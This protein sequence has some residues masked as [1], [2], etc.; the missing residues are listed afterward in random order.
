MKSFFRKAIAAAVLAVSVATAGASAENPAANGDWK[1]SVQSFTFHKFN[2]VDALD[3]TAQLGLKYIELYP[4]HKMGPEFG[5]AVF[6][7]ELTADQRDQLKK[8]AADRGVKI[9]SSGVWTPS[10]DELPK[11]FEFARDMGME[12]VSMEPAR[13]DWDL[14][15][16]LADRYK[17]AVACHNHPNADSYW[18]PEI[19]LDNIEHR[20]HRL[21]SCADV[22]HFKRMELNAVESLRKLQGRIVSLHFKDIAPKEGAEGYDDVVWTTGV[23]DVPAMLAELKRQ[24][25]AGYFTIEYE[26]SWDNN[27]PL[28]AESIANFRAAAGAAD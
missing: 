18:K 9:V 21:G 8:M 11:V 27:V 23:L 12:F 4:G 5:D 22:G 17:I 26:A 20:S 10:R 3:K 6:G 19:L 24:K 15:E 16:E 28:I 14:V 7:Y 25:F 1:L 2:V 13:A